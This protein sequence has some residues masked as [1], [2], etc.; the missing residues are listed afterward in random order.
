MFCYN[1]CFISGRKETNNTVLRQF[2]WL[3]VKRSQYGIP[4]EKSHT[5]CI[6]HKGIVNCEQTKFHNKENTIVGCKILVFM[7]ND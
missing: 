6:V 7:S 5:F 4:Q 3:K 2:Q 1:L